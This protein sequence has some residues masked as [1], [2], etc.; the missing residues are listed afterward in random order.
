MINELSDFNFSGQS[1]K[2]PGIQQVPRPMTQTKKKFN[3]LQ[4]FLAEAAVV[5]F[6]LHEAYECA[7]SFVR[8]R[9]K[10]QTQLFRT[11]KIPLS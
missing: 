5:L 4:N 8:V 9:L 3:K 6:S 1:L 11:P 7:K 2:P 10:I